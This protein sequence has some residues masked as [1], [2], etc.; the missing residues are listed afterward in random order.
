MPWGNH[1]R[2]AHHSPSGDGDSS[3]ALTGCLC[4]PMHGMRG[5]SFA[6]GA[7]GGLVLGPAKKGADGGIV[8]AVL[9]L[10]ISVKLVV[11]GRAELGAG[12]GWVESY[13]LDTT[14]P[15]GE[16][17]GAAGGGTDTT[18]GEEAESEASV[19]M[20]WEMDEGPDCMLAAGTPATGLLVACGGPP[21]GPAAPCLWSCEQHGQG[22]VRTHV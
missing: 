14:V 2:G 15:S 20:D 8:G 18:I 5:S 1:F 13:F 11:R 21:G 12:A 4:C 17:D 9:V 3:C 16:A 22:I 10:E 6:R 7:A 19:R